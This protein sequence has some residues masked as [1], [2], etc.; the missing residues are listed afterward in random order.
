MKNDDRLVHTN[1]GD[2]DI[3]RTLRNRDWVAIGLVASVCGLG[4]F[5]LLNRAE[6]VAALVLISGALVIASCDLRHLLIPDALALGLFVSGLFATATIS[7]I[8][9]QDPWLFAPWPM[10][11]VSGLAGAGISAAALGGLRWAWLRIRGIE[12]IGFGDVKLAGA[13]GAWLGPIDVFSALL[14]ASLAG[15]AVAG[16]SFPRHRPGKSFDP[17]ERVPFGA[18][19]APAAWL[20]FVLMRLQPDL[21]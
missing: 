8:Q 3:L 9:P 21:R 15:L 12:A 1:P 7:A 2:L 18:L 20:V 19:L 13:V 16:V 10:T 4:G 5:I 14:V 6:A 17:S 11:V